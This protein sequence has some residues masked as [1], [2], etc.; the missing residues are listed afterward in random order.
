MAEAGGCN[1]VS[2]EADEM[3][4]AASIGGPLVATR[5]V[6]WLDVPGESGQ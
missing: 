2:A 6:H 5:E 1:S 4:Q 3:I